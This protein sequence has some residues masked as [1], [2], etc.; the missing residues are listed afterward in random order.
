M[1]K[2]ASGLVGALVVGAALLHGAWSPATVAKDVKPLKIT[3]S[4]ALTQIQPNNCTAWAQTLEVD[5]PDALDMH[6]RGCDTDEGGVYG[7]D[8]YPCG[9]LAYL[10]ASVNSSLVQN[11]KAS[12]RAMVAAMKQHGCQ[13]YE[14]GTY[15][16]VMHKN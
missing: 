3:P 5:G 15:G 11:T 12:D 8:A 13:A 10:L 16:P 4:P 6:L 14:D 1:S 2:V 9:A 7:P